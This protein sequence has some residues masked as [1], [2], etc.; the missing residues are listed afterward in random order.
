MEQ[1]EGLLHDVAGHA[2]PL[3]FGAPLWE[4]TNMIRRLSSS[5]RTAFE[6]YALSPSTASGF[7]FGPQVDLPRAGCRRKVR[8]EPNPTAPKIEVARLRPDA[9]CTGCPAGTTGPTPVSAPATTPVKATATARSMPK[10]RHPRSTAESPLPHQRQGHHN[11][12][13]RPGHFNKVLLRS[14]KRR[15]F[16]CETTT[17]RCRNKSGQLGERI[18]S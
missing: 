6:S 12:H 2:Q 5:R 17:E 8:P 15:V 13:A 11:S 10:S 4:I 3:M 14:Q 7:R 9:G 1:S 16:V 18:H